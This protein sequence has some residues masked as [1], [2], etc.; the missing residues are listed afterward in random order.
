MLKDPAI[1][2]RLADAV[3]EVYSTGVMD[4]EASDKSAV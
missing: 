3:L 2:G 1:C 4:L